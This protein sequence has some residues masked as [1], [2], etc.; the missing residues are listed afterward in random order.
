MKTNIHAIKTDGRS[1]RP[2]TTLCGRSGRKS[3]NVDSQTRATL[4][5]AS[6]GNFYAVLGSDP[7]QGPTCGKCRQVAGLWR[8]RKDGE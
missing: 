7:F 4:Y 2:A 8:M 1:D 5:E 3:I 6:A